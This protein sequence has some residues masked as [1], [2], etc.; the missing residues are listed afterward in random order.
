LRIS[1]CDNFFI[2]VQILSEKQVTLPYL[3]WPYLC[4]G[5]LEAKLAN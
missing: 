3:A 4:C 2:R 1:G 5:Q